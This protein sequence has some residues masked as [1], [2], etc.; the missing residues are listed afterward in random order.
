MM[1]TTCRLNILLN[2]ISWICLLLFPIFLFSCRKPDKKPVQIEIKTKLPEINLTVYN[3]APLEPVPAK[4]DAFISLQ[5]NYVYRPKGDAELITIN[6]GDT[7][8]SGGYYKIAFIPD[9]DCCVY[10]FQAD[11]S[12]QIFQLFPM[13]SFKGVAINNFNPVKK[14]TTYIIPARNKSFVLDE[15]KGMERIYLLASRNQNA[16]LEYLY[17]ELQ[18]GN[19]Q[20]RFRSA[21]MKLKHHVSKMRGIKG[22]VSDQPMD[23][24]WEETGDMFSIMGMR[25]EKLCEDCAHIVEFFHE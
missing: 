11:S 20:A 1:L 19:N 14:G 21:Q 10:I 25:L 23:V 13:T 12:G 18:N 2:L 5:A 15:R 17:N 9:E 6:N 4:A 7:L 3:Q 22:V 8:H 16:E 24:A